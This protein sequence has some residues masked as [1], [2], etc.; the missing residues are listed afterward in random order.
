MI[1]SIWRSVFF[2]RKKLILDV[3]QHIRQSIK[4]Y[5]KIEEKDHV[6]EMHFA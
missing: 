1:D 5:G 4:R 3:L 2:L 6:R